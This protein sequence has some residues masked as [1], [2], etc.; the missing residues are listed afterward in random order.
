MK[1]ANGNTDAFST[2]FGPVRVPFNKF[3]SLLADHLITAE[4]CIPF[5]EAIDADPCIEQSSK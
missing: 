5:S 2:F 3:R 4:Q 1:S